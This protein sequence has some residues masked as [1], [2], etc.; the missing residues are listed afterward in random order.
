MLRLILTVVLPLLLPT[1]LWFLWMIAAGRAAERGARWQDAP[2][3][4]L[5]GTGVVLAGVL[6][7]FVSVHYGE[8]GGHYVPSQYI[9]GKIVPGHLER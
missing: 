2:W 3:P 1:A 7:Y 6:L 4:W 9:D 5:A 8:K